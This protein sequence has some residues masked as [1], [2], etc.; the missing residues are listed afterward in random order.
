MTDWFGRD[1]ILSALLHGGAAVLAI[2][3]LFPG[4]VN[5]GQKA[6]VMALV[7]GGVSVVVDKMYPRISDFALGYGL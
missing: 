2:Y 1:T 6:L 3:Y 4:T 5:L 7:V